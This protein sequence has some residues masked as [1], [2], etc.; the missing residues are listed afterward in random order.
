MKEMDRRDF[1]KTVAIGGAVLATGDALLHK[2]LEAAPSAGQV[3]VGNWIPRLL[4]T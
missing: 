4:A 3:E 1:M 2:P